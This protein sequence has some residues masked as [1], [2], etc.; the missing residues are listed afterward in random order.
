MFP[1][2][3]EYWAETRLWIETGQSKV[4]DV[5]AWVP[6]HLQLAAV[7]VVW[8][9][10]SLGLVPLLQGLHELDMMNVYVGRLLATAEPGPGLVFAWH[11]WSLCRGVGFLFITYELASLSLA[12][13]TGERLSTSSRRWWRWGLGVG[14]L[15][16]DVVIKFFC[17]EP[18]RQVLAARLAA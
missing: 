1:P 9:Y 5:G 18:V 15:G 17:L 14:F 11:P 7:M 4:Y 3:T 10:L 13:L 8:G 12:R 6:F 16:L 2:G